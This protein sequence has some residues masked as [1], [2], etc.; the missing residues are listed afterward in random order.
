MGW[1]ALLEGQKTFGKPSQWC[2]RA[3]EGWKGSK[4]P[5]KYS[6]GFGR[7]FWS[8]ERGGEVLQ[9]GQQGSEG[10]SVGLGWFGRPFQRDGRVWESQ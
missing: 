4:S 1:E 5:S 2:G 7:L 9:E 3:E 6:G 8:A 10:F